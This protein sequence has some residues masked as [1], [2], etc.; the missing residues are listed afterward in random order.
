MSTASTLY[1]YNVAYLVANLFI[2]GRCRYALV[3]IDI[4]DCGDYPDGLAARDNCFERYAFAEGWGRVWEETV[5]DTRYPRR[6]PFKLKEHLEYMGFQW[7]RSSSR[8]R[9]PGLSVSGTSP[10]PTSRA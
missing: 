3:D 8:P 2:G 7:C 10:S 1:T 9:K 4:L 6:Q 5:F